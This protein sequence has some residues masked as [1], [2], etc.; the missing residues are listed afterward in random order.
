MDDEYTAIA[1]VSY[2]IYANLRAGLRY[3]FTTQ[4]STSPASEFTENRVTAT[5]RMTF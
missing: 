5:L 4:D 2:E 3:E 1:G